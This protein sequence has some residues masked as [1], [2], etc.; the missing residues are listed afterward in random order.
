LEGKFSMEYCMAV[1]L[2]APRVGLGEFTDE[3]VSRPDMQ[4]MIKRVRFYVDPEA[5]AAG[6]SKMTTILKIHLKDGRVI[7]GRANFGKGSPADPMS[8]G[9]VAEKFLGCAAYAGWPA[10][11]ARQLIEGVKHLEDLPDVGALT[12]LCVG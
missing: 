2:V 9:E 6:Y 5:E 1:L 11:K 3:V 10:E 7:P 8:Y 12:A 4:D